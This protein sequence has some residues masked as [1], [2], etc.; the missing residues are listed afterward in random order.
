MG[1]PNPERVAPSAGPVPTAPR[2]LRAVRDPA[3]SPADAGTTG[4]AWNSLVAATAA[5]GQ[6]GVAVPVDLAGWSP[7]ACDV[8]ALRLQRRLRCGRV[9]LHRRGGP[10]VHLAGVR[11]ADVT[12]GFRVAA[13]AAR[14][15]VPHDVAAGWTALD[16][17]ESPARR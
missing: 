13:E 6:P 15:S 8:L 11:V 4:F 2:D 16:E 12:P 10:V 17:A 5:G 1:A 7:R 14:A 9:T 3:G